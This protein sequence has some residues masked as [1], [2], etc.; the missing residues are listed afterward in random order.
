[1]TFVKLANGYEYDGE[2]LETAKAAKRF[3][4]QRQAT[5]K[6]AANLTPEQ[7]ARARYGAWM[8]GRRSGEFEGFFLEQLA[9]LHTVAR[10]YIGRNA[11]HTICTCG[12]AVEQQ[13]FD[14][15]T[16]AGKMAMLSTPGHIRVSDQTLQSLFVIQNAEPKDDAAKFVYFC[17]SC[18]VLAAAPIDS[19]RDE[20]SQSTARL[21]KLRESHVCRESRATSQSPAA[22]A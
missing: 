7:A 13:T 4:R 18:G 9:E 6:A 3:E 10:A 20:N 21:A 17:Q 1:M 14:D 8:Q 2:L 22:G 5:L 12:L 15:E 16:A 11:Q 19:I